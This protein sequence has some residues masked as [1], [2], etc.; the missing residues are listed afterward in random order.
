MLCVKNYCHLWYRFNNFYKM[1]GKYFMKLEYALIITAYNS[2]ITYT[3]KG[4]QV[5]WTTG[6]HF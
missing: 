4:R 3:I 2:I 6:L 1:K 5:I